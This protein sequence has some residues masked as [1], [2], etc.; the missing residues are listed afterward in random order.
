MNILYRKIVTICGVLN[1]PLSV[2]EY[3]KVFRGFGNDIVISIG[4]LLVVGKA[5]ERRFIISAQFP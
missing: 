2:L 3:A 1:I 4:A 5:I